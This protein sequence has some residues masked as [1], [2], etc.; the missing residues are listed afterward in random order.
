MLEVWDKALYSIREQLDAHQYNSW[1]KPIVCEAVTTEAIVLKVPDRFFRDWVRDN[2][3]ELLRAQLARGQGRGA[4]AL[5]RSIDLY[6]R[7]PSSTAALQ[8]ADL[9]MDLGDPVEAEAWY[10][11]ALEH[12]PASP[13]A[14]AGLV[15][16]AVDTG[17]TPRARELA[18]RYLAVYPDHVHIALARAELLLAEGDVQGG[19]EQARAAVDRAPYERVAWITWAHALWESGDSEGAI[20][21]LLEARDMDPYDIG[22]RLRL[23]DCLL[24]VGRAVEARSNL[25]AAHDLQEEPQP[26]VE[27][28][29][30]RAEAAL[31]EQIGGPLISIP[32]ASSREGVNP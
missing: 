8:I 3:L 4:E 16:C 26:E 27:A 17:D 21:A 29:L 30:A 12:Q 32:A 1:F 15:R 20:Q 14:M 13:E 24:D 6:R 10:A 25:R 28:A 23:A 2:Y 7:S 18:D 11:L 9:S 5:G 31:A 22:L 19:L